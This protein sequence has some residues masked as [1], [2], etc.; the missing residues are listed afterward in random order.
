MTTWVVLRAAGIGAYVMLFLA[1]AWGLVG[2]T[3]VLGKRVSK[4]TSTTVHQYLGT[5]VLPLLAVH[6][7]GLLVDRFRPFRPI[8]LVVPL[9]STFRPLAVA[10]GILAM[11]AL[12]VVLL[13]SW[14]R[15]HLSLVTWRA[16]HLFATPAFILAMVHGIFTGT[17][18]ARPWL[19]WTYLITGS[20]VLFLLLVRAFT[21]GVRPERKPLPAGTQPRTVSP[22]PAPVGGGSTTAGAEEGSDVVA[23]GR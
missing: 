9:H 19:W 11:D 15:K 5:A 16:L 13:T 12:I 22:R 8:D 21:F 17:D 23:V 20:I 14:L 18:S 1:V 10:F 4:V 7:G 3:A 2:P 6:L